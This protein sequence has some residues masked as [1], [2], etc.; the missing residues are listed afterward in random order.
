MLVR[1]LRG[2]TTTGAIRPT[3]P[4]IR[5]ATCSAPPHLPSGASSAQSSRRITH[6]LWRAFEAGRATQAS[7]PPSAGRRECSQVASRLHV[8]RNG[9]E[10]P[11]R[12][13]SQAAGARSFVCDHIVSAT[14]LRGVLLAV[15]RSSR[16]HS[17]RGG[18]ASSADTGLP[19]LSTLAAYRRA[20][21]RRG[22]GE[23]GGADSPRR[24]SCG[25]GSSHRV[26]VRQAP[27]LLS[28]DCTIQ[29]ELC[30]SAGATAASGL[31][32]SIL[33]FRLRSA[34]AHGATTL[35]RP[36]PRA[37]AAKAPRRPPAGVSPSHRARRCA[38]GRGRCRAAPRAAP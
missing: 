1:T 10:P 16:L 8:T 22:H 25:F 2:R 12:G 14:R 31:G 29:P 24:T 38:K 34:A 26:R 4:V 21:H 9:T 6:L 23:C 27:I 36:W 13:F 37:P 11:T 3:H 30:S 32:P 5:P 7:R 33:R 17:A 19:R 35:A 15:P 28:T 18:G 20:Q